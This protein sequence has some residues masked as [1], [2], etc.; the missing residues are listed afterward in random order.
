M[1]GVRRG[2]PLV[3]YRPGHRLGWLRYLTGGYFMQVNKDFNKAMEL[4]KAGKL[5]LALKRFDKAVDASPDEFEPIFQ[6]GV[7]Y[8]RNRDAE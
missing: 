1:G 8:F 6:R 5:K 3:A 2:W 4:L 7:C